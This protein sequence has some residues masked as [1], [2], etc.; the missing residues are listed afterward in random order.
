MYFGLSSAPSTFI[1]AMIEVLRPFME[2]IMAIY[3]FMKSLFITKLR[4]GI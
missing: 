3:F 1:R 4:K 2:E